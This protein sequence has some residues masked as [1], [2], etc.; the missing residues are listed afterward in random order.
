[1]IPFKSSRIR[2]NSPAGIP[3]GEQN[4]ITSIFSY[5]RRLLRL[6]GAFPLASVSGEA[7][8]TGFVSALLFSAKTGLSSAP[9]L[10]RLRLTP[11]SGAAVGVTFAAAGLTGLAAGFTASGLSGT[12]TG[13]GAT[14]GFGLTGVFTSV[15]TG[16]F[17]SFGAAATAF[18]A[19]AAPLLPL[20]PPPAP[21]PKEPTG[22]GSVGSGGFTLPAFLIA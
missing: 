22:T 18:A 16:A 3:A 8:L 14:T 15:F 10:L 2:Q 9:A 5:S 13:F 6:L 20:L 21:A 12:T 19:P 1:M 7:V 4:I 11:P 17:V